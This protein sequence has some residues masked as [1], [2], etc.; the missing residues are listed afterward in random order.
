[1]S[2]LIRENTLKTLKLFI[3]LLGSLSLILGSISPVYAQSERSKDKSEERQKVKNTKRDKSHRNDRET[4]RKVTRNVT[5][6]VVVV[7]RKRNFRNVIVV[8]P[9]GHA[10]HGYGHYTDDN[11]AWKWLAFTAITLKILDNLNEQAQREHE[12]AQV[13]ATIAP[14]GE[15]ITWSTTDAKGVVTATKEGKNESG[16]TCREFQQTITVGGNTEDAYGTACLQ[17]DGS[18]KIVN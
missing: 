2:Y 17:A 18:W 14:V 10:Y 15:K 7:P 3:I 1:M 4:K 8:R 9:H 12:A 6:K 5:K 13:K 11:N 16:L